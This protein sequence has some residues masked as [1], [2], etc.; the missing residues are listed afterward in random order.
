MCAIHEVSKQVSTQQSNPWF[1]QL[2]C[3]HFE[4][5]IL[6]FVLARPPTR[7]ATYHIILELAMSPRHTSSSAREYYVTDYIVHNI[8][9][10]CHSFVIFLAFCPSKAFD[11]SWWLIDLKL[12][13]TWSILSWVILRFTGRQRAK[14]RKSVSAKNLYWTK[15]Y[16]GPMGVLPR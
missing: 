2:I 6:S 3:S 1:T 5:V 11:Q 4:R 7:P 12:P 10:P 14:K 13:G 16:W 9:Y 8:P 15:Q